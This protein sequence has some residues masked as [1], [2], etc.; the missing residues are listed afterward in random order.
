M[1]APGAWSKPAQ[2]WNATPATIDVDH[3]RVWDWSNPQALRGVRVLAET[4]AAGRSP[5]VPRRAVI[6]NDRG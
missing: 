1:H 5:A 3:A 6:I 2:C 4:E